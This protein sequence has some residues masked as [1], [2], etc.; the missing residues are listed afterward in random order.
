M[1]QNHKRMPQVGP[2]NRGE[3]APSLAG[4]PWGIFWW[5]VEQF[6]CIVT[7]K[8]HGTG[9]E[10]WQQ[11]KHHVP[12]HENVHSTPKTKHHAVGQGTGLGLVGG[13]TTSPPQSIFVACFICRMF[14]GL[15]LL[16]LCILYPIS[17]L[18]LLPALLIQLFFNKTSRRNPTQNHA[19]RKEW[20]DARDW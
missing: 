4:L 11:K 16:L 7:S 2:L 3:G 12:Y 13:L 10:K 1:F 5:I 17:I 6:F 15:C 18:I 8:I 9:P 19:S 20:H 14:S